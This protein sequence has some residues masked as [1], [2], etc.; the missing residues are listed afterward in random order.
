MKILWI[1]Q[2]VTDKI[3]NDILAVIHN[4]ML[5]S[6]RWYSE[7][8]GYDIE[9][10]V[11]FPGALPENIFTVSWGAVHL[12]DPDLPENVDVFH[13]AEHIQKILLSS[14]FDLIV[15][16]HY[17]SSF[18]FPHLGAALCGLMDCNFINYATDFQLDEHGVTVTRPTLTGELQ[19]KVKFPVICTAWHLKNRASLEPSQSLFKDIP[20]HTHTFEKQNLDKEIILSKARLNPA[21]TK[22]AGENNLITDDASEAVEWL[23]REIVHVRV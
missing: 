9:A 10:L 1:F 20:V 17:G 2:S 18:L 12:T 6:A 5:D 8:S 14:A 16:P 7:N 3:N 22:M 4:P 19:Q 13:L 15:F 11:L 21:F 23:K